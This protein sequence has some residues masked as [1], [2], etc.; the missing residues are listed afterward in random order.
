LCFFHLATK[1]CVTLIAAPDTF[2]VRR[3]VQDAWNYVLGS[4]HE[5]IRVSFP[6]Q[7]DGFVGLCEIEKLVELTVASLPN[8]NLFADF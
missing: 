2:G 5:T 4:S 3:F 8:S 6:A 1:G 7:I